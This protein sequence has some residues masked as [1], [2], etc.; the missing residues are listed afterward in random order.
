MPPLAFGI[1]EGGEMV[2]P[3]GIV[4][5]G[6]LISS[7]VFTLFIIPIFYSYVDK[8]TRKMHKK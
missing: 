1:G 5:I 3:M 2:A 8:E 7:T 6:G 4:V